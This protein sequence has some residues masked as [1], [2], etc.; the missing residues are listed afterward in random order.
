MAD[1]QIVIDLDRMTIADLATFDDTSKMGPMVDL[2]DR[3]VE[4]GARHRPVTQLQSIITALR[5]QID[6]MTNAKN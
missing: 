2:L 4:G 1:T 5:V 3:V 6:G